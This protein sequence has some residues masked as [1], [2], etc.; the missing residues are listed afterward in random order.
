MDARTVIAAFLLAPLGAIGQ[1][2]EGLA[3]RLDRDIRP[4][5]DAS[6]RKCHD[7]RKAKGG[8]DL[9]SFPAGDRALR[10]RALWRKVLRQ[11]ESQDMPPEGEK[12][13]D[14]AVRER[15]LVWLKEAVA[16]PVS[17]DPRERD[18]GPPLLR[19]LNRAEYVLTLKDLLGI[20]L[21]AADKAGIPEDP[22]ESSYDT[23]SGALDLPAALLEKY[24]AAA[25]HAVDAHLATRAPRP[26]PDLSERDAARATLE[27]FARRAY[28]RPAR[29]EEIDA[30]LP[31]FDRARRRGE[32][33]A[34]A[35][36]L[37]LKAV[38]V[39]PNFLYRVEEP[40]SAPGGAVA[41]PVSDLELAVRLSYFLWS[42]MPD[43]ELLCLAERGRLSLPEVYDAQLRR[44]QADPK[45]KALTDRFGVQWLQL[46]KL[47]TARPSADS[48]PGFTSELR[49]A[50]VDETFT[51]F[52]RV[53]T[54]DRSVLEFLDADY[55]YV[56][57]ALAKHYGLEGVAG[58]QMKKVS[59]KPEQHRGGLLGMG[60]ILT[61][62][63][64]SSRTSPTIRGK[65]ILEVLFGT[66]P[67]PPPPDAGILKEP[68]RKGKAPANLRELLG[69][70]AREA[71]CASCH[72]K[73][74]PLGFALEN[75][76]GVGRWRAS[77]GGAPIDVAGRLPT[78]ETF[79]GF[80]DLKRVLQSRR[81]LFVR[82]L[83]EQMATF[84]LG[85][86]LSD[87]DE[88]TIREIQED[89]ENGGYRFSRLVTGVARSFPFKH[90]R[91]AE[92][93]E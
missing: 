74:D 16:A 32:P 65:W 18:P 52:D 53:R 35:L 24:F 85:R 90:R 54:E 6:C 89:L 76:D 77:L 82:N 4:I 79:D 61:L 33:F 72:Q 81:P 20:D 62:T 7:S 36:R 39:S 49:Q 27:R 44:M 88:P 84:A 68:P 67:P 28:R 64:H 2:G 70:H 50:M 93:K 45:A 63:S 17:V 56:N 60:S 40:R 42:T 10:Q 83:V 41:A 5:L 92:R 78:G 14:A 91:S 19:R 29:V 22:M 26:D 75:F 43:D 11:V 37:A 71:A 1:D 12:P 55:T 15:L 3:A 66:R 38:L 69:L 34:P 57:Q 80:D 47:R 46:W 87:D 59:L 21:D 8:V 30:L 73:I 58:R 25:D 51:F 13:L 48:F 23:Q 9:A 86:E 31:L